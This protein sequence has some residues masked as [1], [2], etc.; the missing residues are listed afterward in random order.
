MKKVLALIFA[1]LML[2]GLMVGCEGGS[3]GAIEISVLNYLD[4]SDPTASGDFEKIW[5]AFEEAN[6]DIKLI[7]ED[8]FNEPF[9]EKTEA[10]AA[11]GELPDVI[12]CWPSGRSTT[13]H[14]QKLLYDLAPL[15]ERDGLASS[16]GSGILDPSAQAGGYLA[17]IP[18][19]VTAT[20]AFFV[21]HEVLEECG[22]TPAKTYSELVAQVPVLKANGYETI[23]M[24]NED[25]WVMQSC[26]FSLVAG[27]F[28]GEGWDQKILDGQ[29]KFTDDDFVAALA[30]I[31][32]MYKDGVIEKSSLAIGYGEGPGLFATN[33]GAYYIDGDWRV[34]A[35][36]TDEETGEALFTPDQQKNISITV[37]P[38]ID[39]AGVQIPAKTNTVVLGTGWGINA[40]IDED[41]LE[42][43]WTLV[44]WLCGQEVLTYMLDSGQL[45]APSRIDVNMDGLDLEPLQV[46]M[47]NLSNEYDRATVVIDGSFEGPVYTPLNDGLQ[48]L[49]N[50]DITPEEVAELVQAAFEDWKAMQ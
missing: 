9:H 1:V 47:A 21:N 19:G 3:G 49:G 4:L 18:Q 25:T 42:A 39:V 2:A 35:F 6:P 48:A 20:N 44:K 45:S 40:D 8:S 16:Y 24:P 11:A 23:I 7:R 10:Y 33:K 17:M 15:V 28:C 46:A 26:L 32:Q 29:A 38:E 31:E 5:D 12:F 50:G 41:K 27:R 34:S 36:L 43:A 22:L 14:T 13:L 37:F 30:F